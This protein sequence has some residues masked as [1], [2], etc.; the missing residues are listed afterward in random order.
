LTLYPESASAHLA[1]G[2]LRV[3]QKRAVDAVPELAS[4]AALSPDE[5]NYTYVYGVSLYSTGRIA[6]A[7]TVLEKARHRF[8]ANVQIQSAIQAYCDDQHRQSANDRRVAAICTASPAA[9]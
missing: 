8:P 2:L 7:L 9:K 6:E 3:R 5:S 1:M 4:A